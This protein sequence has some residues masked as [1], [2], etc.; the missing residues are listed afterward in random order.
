MKWTTL[1]ELRHLTNISD[2]ALLAFLEQNPQLCQV[3]AAAGIVVDLNSTKLQA[4]LK[5]VVSPPPTASEELE[6]EIE[7]KVAAL[8]EDY[9][10]RILLAAL[11][12]VKA[13]KQSLTD[14]Q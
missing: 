4:L 6:P 5:A 1:K 9:F 3:D 10:E 2:S 7:A 8:L 11:E 14:T 12:R 13:M